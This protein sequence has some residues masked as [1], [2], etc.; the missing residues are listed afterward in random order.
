[1]EVEELEKR[2]SRK[3]TSS[4]PSSAL[5]NNLDDGCLI[6]HSS[7]HQLDSSNAKPRDSPQGNQALE[8]EQHT[9]E[10][11]QH[12]VEVQQHTV[13]VAP[14]LGDK[15]EQGKKQHNNLEEGKGQ[16]KNTWDHSYLETRTQKSKSSPTDK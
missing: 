10:V 3:I 12:N 1:M 15:L 14:S 13:A 6:S 5:I 7:T 16:D 8:V 9:V 4:S 2:K 11:E